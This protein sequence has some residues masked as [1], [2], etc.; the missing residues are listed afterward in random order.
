MTATATYP[1]A[2]RC[3]Q[4]VLEAAGAP[5]LTAACYCES[6]R[7]AARRF[8]DAPGAPPV[9]N[10]DG[11]I[12]YSLFRKD[13]VR[14]LKGGEHLQAHRLKETAPSRRVVATCCQSPMFLDFAPGHWLSLYRDRLPDDA[15]PVEIAVMTGDLPA[16]HA[17]PK[18]LPA[19]ATRPA[20]FMFRLL[21]SFAAMG[22]RKPRL[23]F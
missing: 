14:V 12:D 5:I 15:P 6:C 23:D 8:E 1:S 16:D 10:P 17:H 9:L 2:C 11:G 21:A 18:G 7:L 3:G 20:K 4:V 19:Y 13:R 22:L